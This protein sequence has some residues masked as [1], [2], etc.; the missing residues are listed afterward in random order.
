MILGFCRWVLNV[1]FVAEAGGDDSGVCS[2][3]PGGKSEH[4]FEV[5]N[6]AWRVSFE[7]YVSA[8]SVGTPVA[9]LMG[10][11]KVALV[12]PQV[13]ALM[14]WQPPGLLG[15]FVGRAAVI[16]KSVASFVVAVSVAAFARAQEA[17][18]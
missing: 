10:V 2:R 17:F 14:F 8:K 12:R 5:Q 13:L 11:P 15:D 7:A 6:F 9:R 18:C 4:N 3:R 16:S 1:L